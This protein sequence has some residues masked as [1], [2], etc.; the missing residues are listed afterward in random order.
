MAMSLAGPRTN[1]RPGSLLFSGDTNGTVIT[2]S[3]GRE[4]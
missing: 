1:G 4:Y 2:W 3:S